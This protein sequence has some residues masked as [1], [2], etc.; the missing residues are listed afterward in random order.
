MNFHPWFNER[1]RLAFWKRAGA[2]VKLKQHDSA[3]AR[4]F[5]EAWYGI[6]LENALFMDVW[7]SRA[8]WRLKGKKICLTSLSF[9]CVPLGV[10]CVKTSFN[11]RFVLH[12]FYLTLVVFR[13]ACA[14]GVVAQRRW[15][16]WLLIDRLWV[17]QKKV[18]NCIFSCSL[19]GQTHIGVIGI[20][21]R[22]PLWYKAEWMEE[23]DKDDMETQVL[24]KQQGWERR[25]GINAFSVPTAGAEAVYWADF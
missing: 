13:V 18:D 25:A 19:K 14:G 16:G 7:C 23:A 12:F 6:L 21:T 15:G 9:L 22:R 3:H 10:V 2:R 17:S 8:G 20:F 4:L 11:E 24:H 5:L 1:C